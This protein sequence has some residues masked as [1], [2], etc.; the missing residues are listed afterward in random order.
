MAKSLECLIVALYSQHYLQNYCRDCIFC[1]G[2]NPIETVDS[3]C[4]LGHVITYDLDNSRDIE[5]TCNDLINGKKSSHF[6]ASCKD[7]KKL[8]ENW[9]YETQ[10]S[11][12]GLTM[13]DHEVLISLQARAKFLVTYST[14]SITVSVTRDLN[15]T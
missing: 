9:T 12:E 11:F 5:N 6:E 1:V 3:F 13:Y 10:K 7:L 14:M 8:Q 2:N 4:R 15:M